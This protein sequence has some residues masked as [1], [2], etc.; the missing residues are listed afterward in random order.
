MGADHAVNYRT[1]DASAN[2]IV[3]HIERNGG[4]AV[5][6]AADVFTANG[7]RHLVE[8][9]VAAGSEVSGRSIAPSEPPE[10][11]RFVLLRQG[12]TVHG[13]FGA[14]DAPFVGLKTLEV[15]GHRIV[16]LRPH[17][18]ADHAAVRAVQHEHHGLAAALGSGLAFRRLAHDADAQELRDDAADGGFIEA[19]VPRDL[20]PARLLVDPD[21]TEHPGGVDESRSLQL[22]HYFPCFNA[23]VGL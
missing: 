7:C 4:Q 21:I 6:V 15:H 19:E 14:R 2:A 11:V 10:D 20:D 8:A 3:E 16:G 17:L 9:T 12:D 18:D 23:L 5:A 1:S 13:A 22:C